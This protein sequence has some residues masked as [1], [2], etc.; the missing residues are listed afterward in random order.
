[1]DNKVKLVL[2]YILI[3]FSV[4]YLIVNIGSIIIESIYFIKH[5]SFVVSLEAVGLSFA[6][7]IIMPIL[8]II[9]T[10]FVGKI[11]KAKNIAKNKILNVLFYIIYTMSIL[12]FV[13]M[14]NY[15]LTNPDFI[16]EI[17]TIPFGKIHYILIACHTLL[18]VPLIGMVIALFML[19]INYQISRNNKCFI[20][21]ISKN[22]SKMDC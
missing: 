22:K 5:E 8:I 7:R 2:S 6:I 4:I 18:M 11:I 13:L 14:F 15:I 3:I 12:L 9:L 20:N 16:S 1:M 10:L 21:I 17:Q 19:L